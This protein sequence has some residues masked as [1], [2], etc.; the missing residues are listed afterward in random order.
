LHASSWYYRGD[1]LLFN[2]PGP[3]ARLQL[4]DYNCARAASGATLSCTV[5]RGAQL[6]RAPELPRGDEEDGYANTPA[7]DMWSAGLIIFELLTGGLAYYPPRGVGG[8]L[9][10]ARERPVSDWADRVRAGRSPEEV[11]PLPGGSPPALVGIMRACLQRD[12]SARIT[13]EAAHAWLCPPRLPRERTH[14][15]VR[16]AVGGGRE[17]VTGSRM[18]ALVL[19]LCT[20]PSSEH[21]S[22]RRPCSGRE[23]LPRLPSKRLRVARKQQLPPP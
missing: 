18:P 14:A 11:L 23:R 10:G 7:A 4:I 5:A 22:S 2:A 15:E 20:L 8:A 21:R 3:G 6:W 19:P 16:R 12:P 17:V 13:A 1:N 9:A